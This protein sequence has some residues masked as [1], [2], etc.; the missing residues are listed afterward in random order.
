MGLLEWFLNVT[1]RLCYGW[2][3]NG[4]MVLRFKQRKYGSGYEGR[5]LMM[6]M[7]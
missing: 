3:M 1:L 7:K 5:A 2:M 6:M 4:C